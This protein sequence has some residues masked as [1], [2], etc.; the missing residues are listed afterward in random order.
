MFVPVLD[1]SRNAYMFAQALDNS[2][3]FEYWIVSRHGEHFDKLEPTD[4]RLRL[5]RKQIDEAASTFKRKL[6]F[7]GQELDCRASLSGAGVITIRP[8]TLDID[9]RASPVLMLFNLYGDMRGQVA[10]ALRTI[11]DAMGREL[12]Q[13]ASL[14]IDKLDRM[15]K[16]PR[17]LLFLALIFGKRGSKN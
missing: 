12:T 2:G 9:G 13:S 16:W 8:T 4:Q 7:E 14:E 11:L 6:P 5:I 1:L 3:E 15:L 10:V 17:P